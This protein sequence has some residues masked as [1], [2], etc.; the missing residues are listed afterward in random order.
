MRAP[1]TTAAAARS[2]RAP[3]QAM[4]QRITSR[5]PEPGHQDV[6]DAHRAAFPDRPRPT[7]RTGSPHARTR[8]RDP[9]RGTSPRAQPYGYER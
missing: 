1:I 7:G 3:L 9:G 5:L 4:M 8:P 2:N 6:S